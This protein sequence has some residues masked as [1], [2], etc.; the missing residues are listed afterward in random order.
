VR[1]VERRA[2]YILIGFDAGTLIVHLGMSGS[3]RMV[4]P[5]RRPEAARSLGHRAGLRA[6]VLRF[7]DPRRFGSL[8]WTAGDPRA[9]PLLAKLAPSP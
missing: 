5:A 2:K 1:S 4:D 3:L 6:R 8:H 7:H 9:H